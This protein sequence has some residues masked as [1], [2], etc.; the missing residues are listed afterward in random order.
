MTVD[1]RP[2]EQPGKSATGKLVVLKFDGDFQQGFRVLLEIGD[3]GHRPDTELAGALPPDLEIASRLSEWQQHYRNLNASSLVNSRIQPQRIIYGGTVNRLEDCWQAATELHQQMVRW[4]SF[5]S[6]RRLD[7]RLRESLSISDAI[8]VLI[9]TPDPLLRRLPWH[10]WDFVERYPKTEIALSA[11]ISE[12]VEVDPTSARD[13]SV[14][15]LAV[16]GNSQGIDVQTDRQFLSGLPQGNVVFLVEPSRQEINQYL[17]EQAWDILFFAGHSS[18]EGDRGLV[19]INPQESLSLEEL[20]Y[21]LKKAISQGLQLAIFNSCDGLGLAQSLESLSLPQMII[22]R[23]P[24]PDRVAQRF[25]KSFLKSFSSGRSLYLSVREAREQLQSIEDRFPCATWLPIIC[26]N[27]TKTPPSWQALVSGEE[28]RYAALSQNAPAAAR[29]PAAR[30]RPTFQTVIQD[31]TKHTRHLARRFRRGWIVLLASLLATVCVFN[32]V[33]LSWIQPLELAVYDFTLQQRPDEGADNRL[34]I[35]GITDDDI[36]AQAQNGEQLSRRSLSEASYGQTFQT[37]LSDQSLARLLSTLAQYQPRVI[38][39]DLYRDFAAAPDQSALSARL[40]QD[41][42][43]I[44]VC[45][46]EDFDDPSFS[47]ASID[48]PPEVPLGRV[49]FSDFREDSDGI[50]R[51]HLLG[52][53]PVVRTEGSRCNTDWSF[54][55]QIVAQYLRPAGIE[56][57]FTELGDLQLDDRLIA[58][59]QSQQGNYPPDAGGSEILLNYRSTPEIAPTI[60]LQQFLN[61]QPNADYLTDKIVLI[62]VTAQ[63]GEDDWLTPLHSGEV[64]PGVVV[65]AHM[66]SQL[67]SAVLDNRPLLTPLSLAQQ[68]GWVWV[69]AAVGG[70]LSLWKL[71]GKEIRQFIN[72][73][74]IR[75]L[76]AIAFLYG[77]T[78]LSLIRGYWLPFVSLVLALVLSSLLVTV[79]SLGHFRNW[80]S[81]LFIKSGAEG[82]HN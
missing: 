3:E 77:L 14:K 50:L 76:M 8:R 54:S 72:R 63:D 37:S 31:F 48:P 68:A 52:M 12:S 78:F 26:Q 9:R 69:W 67:L 20:R 27:S 15:I 60:T 64:V 5:E 24:I 49:G 74:S 34:L 62:G 13:R 45:K 28:A 58:V 59:L 41:A 66:V 56:T 30:S 17:W 71:K 25:L 35:V 16:L 42:N 73:L 55:L 33:A 39:L 38:G 6:F 29:L 23:E 43:L 19:Y 18:T 32:P 80:I 47:T 65:Q 57:Q 70:F 82:S 11:P 79:Y 7:L 75:L 2:I 22:M 44:A 46:A 81:L 4:L 36:K 51:R 40:K 53:L 21:G 61:Q 10:L 1:K